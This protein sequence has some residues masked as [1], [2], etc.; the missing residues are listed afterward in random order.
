MPNPRS[1]LHPRIC[2]FLPPDPNADSYVPKTTLS[3]NNNIVERTPDLESL[4][5]RFRFKI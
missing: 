5:L 4:V 1:C 3:G 2:A